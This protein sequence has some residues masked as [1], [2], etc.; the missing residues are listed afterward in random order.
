MKSK[1]NEVVELYIDNKKHEFRII[2]I[3]AIY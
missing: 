1:M 3:K 2:G